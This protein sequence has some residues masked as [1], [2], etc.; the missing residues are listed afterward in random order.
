MNSDS[1]RSTKIYFSYKQPS[2]HVEYTSEILSNGPRGPLFSVTAHDDPDNPVQGSTATA[3][4]SM[5]LGKVRKE[6][7]RMGLGRTGTAVSGPEFFGY[8]MPEVAACIEG[9]DGAETCKNYVCRCLR[10]DSVRKVKTRI[11]RH[12]GESFVVEVEPEL[13]ERPSKRRAAQAA[14][15]RW[16]MMEEDESSA[17]FSEDEDELSDSDLESEEDIRPPR[18][19]KKRVAE[20]VDD[21]S[22]QI[23]TEQLL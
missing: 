17:D 4:W 9:L 20:P 2:R 13:E 21:D 11:R 19:T 8:A 15:Q 14:S 12:L 23:K 1:Y 3:C 16:K 7:N 5:V 6:R 10:M 18:R 22:K